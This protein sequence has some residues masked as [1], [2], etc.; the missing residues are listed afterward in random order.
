MRK[1]GQEPVVIRVVVQRGKEILFSSIVPEDS[2]LLWE[3][4]R[5]VPLDCGATLEAITV[6]PK[7]GKD[8]VDEEAK[9]ARASRLKVEKD[10]TRNPDEPRRAPP[11]PDA[12]PPE[13]PEEGHVHAPAASSLKAFLKC[14]APNEEECVEAAHGGVMHVDVCSCGARRMRNA[15]Q[16]HLEEGAWSK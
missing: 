6:S 10:L 16:G 15:R 5:P 9:R 13:E 8:E 2:G 14:A 1:K 11:L 7:L 3:F 4:P 12:E